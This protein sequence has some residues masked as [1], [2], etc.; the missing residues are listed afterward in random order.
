MAD[1][2]EVEAPADMTISIPGKGV[3]EFTEGE[4]FELPVQMAMYEL[5]GGRVKATKAGKEKM[6]ELKLQTV[7]EAR[8]AKTSRQANATEVTNARSGKQEPQKKGE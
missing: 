3:Q 5:N 8:E 6:K 1:F 4:T 2:I 7:Q